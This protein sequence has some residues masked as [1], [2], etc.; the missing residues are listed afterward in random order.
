VSQIIDNGDVRRCGQIGISENIACEP[1]ASA[2]KPLS[3]EDRTC[4]SRAIF[5]G[6][7]LRLTPQ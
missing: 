5:E 4:R 2:Q 3:N 6:S 1:F 7:R